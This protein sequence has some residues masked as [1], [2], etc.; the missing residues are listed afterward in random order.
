MTTACLYG[1]GVF[2]GMRSYGGKVFRLKAASRPAV[3]LGQGDLARDPDQPRRRWPRRSTTRWPTNGIKDGYIRL[4]VTRGAGALGP[5]PEQVQR[6]AGDHHRRPHP[7]LSEGDVRERPGDRHGQHDPQPSGGPQPADQVAE[8][9]E[10]HHGQDR[11][12]AGRLRRGPDA[13]RTRAKSPSAPATTSSSSSKGVLHDAAD[14]RRHSRRHHPR[15]GH[16]A[17]RAKSDISGAANAARRATTS[18]S[19]TNAS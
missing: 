9:P 11:G 3:G 8:L 17:G 19:P 6:P 15:R 16:R 13:Q 5:R 14:R 2:E 7:A 4:V 1:D 18:S 12:A 10:Q